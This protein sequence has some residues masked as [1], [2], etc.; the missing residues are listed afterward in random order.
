MQIKPTD[1]RNEIGKAVVGQQQAVAR[2]WW[3]WSPR[4]MC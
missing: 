4:A 2:R 3:R 1:L